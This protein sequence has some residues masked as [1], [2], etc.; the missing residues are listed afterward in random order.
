MRHLLTITLVL[1]F[2]LTM[3]GCSED[4]PAAKPAT[5]PSEQAASPAPQAPATAPAIGKAG[6]VTETVNAAGYTYVE[7]DTGS[8]TFWAAAPEFTVQVGD[9]VVV[10]EGMPMPDY[11]SKTL[12]RTF[13][14]VYFVPNVMVGGEMAGGAPGEMPPGHPPTNG[15]TPSAVKTDIDL[16]GVSKAEDGYTIAELY[17]QKA[18][19]SGKP[20]KVRG[21]V[22]KFSPEIM[23]KNWIHLQ[24]GSGEGATSDLTVTSDAS[25][26]LGDTVIITGKLVTGKDFGYGYQYD[27]IIEDAQVAAE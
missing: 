7:V 23:G 5:K 8:E 12:D 22:V 17:A 18:D 3:S 15:G 9:D 10:P 16:S 25:A 6:K 20:V 26:N 4:K 21:K 1:A 14:M 2:A 13:E 19:L 27:L 11:H 24:D